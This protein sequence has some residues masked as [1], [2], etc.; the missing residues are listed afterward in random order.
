M[1]SGGLCEPINPDYEPPKLTT[2]F[3][4]EVYRENEWRVASKHPRVED[5]EW[6]S[7]RIASRGVKTRIFRTESIRTQL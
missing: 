1:S 5:A 7:E 2:V 3:E 4:V 6:A